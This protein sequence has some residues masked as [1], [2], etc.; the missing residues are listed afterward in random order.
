[1]ES[2]ALDE[3]FKKVSGNE[4]LSVVFENLKDESVPALLNVSEQSRR[5]DDMMKMYSMGESGASMAEETLILNANSS[6]VRKLADNPDE[7]IAKQLYTLTLLSQR[8]LSA[9]E[10]KSFLSASFGLLENS[11]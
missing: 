2:K 8:R 3:L 1:M 11:L 10:L 7:N 6:L 4:K 5:F 9:D